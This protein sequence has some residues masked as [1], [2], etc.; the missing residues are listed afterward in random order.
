METQT[1]IKTNIATVIA[2][3][4]AVAVPATAFA[5]TSPGNPT[6]HRGIP[7]DS[8]VISPR[9]KFIGADPDPNVRLEMKRDWDHYHGYMGSQ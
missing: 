4:T 5:Q 1:S 2:L 7:E 9:G 3:L 8:I 6:L